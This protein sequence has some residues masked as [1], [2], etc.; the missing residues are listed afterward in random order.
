MVLWVDEFQFYVI[1]GDDL[2]LGFEDVKS[3]LGVVFEQGLCKGCLCS[4]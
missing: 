1:R 4:R 2:V 3:E